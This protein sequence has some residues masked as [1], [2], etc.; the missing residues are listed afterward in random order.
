MSTAAYKLP[1]EPA[2]GAL[3]R[4]AANPVL[5]LLAVMLV[6]CWFALPWLAFNGYAIG[7]PTR[8]REALMC[9]V[10]V[11][12]CAAWL[13]LVLQLGAHGLV[14]PISIKYLMLALPAIKLLAVYAASQRQL[15][16]LELF[17]HFGGRTQNAVFLLA[18]GYF[19]RGTVDK[20]LLALDQYHFA[21]AI[22]S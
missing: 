8:R 20:A 5:P 12:G 13:L 17:Q 10:A 11:L 7:S 9:G 14:P 1:D 6:G 21:Y 2:P 18:A 4:F 16:A 22:L 3:A 15:R 19:L